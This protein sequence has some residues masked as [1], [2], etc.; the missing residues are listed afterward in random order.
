MT[1]GYVW[2]DA[3]QVVIDMLDDLGYACGELPK[4]AEALSDAFPVIWIVRAGGATDGITDRPIIE[5]DCIAPSRAQ[6]SATA[7]AVR[8]RIA[9]SAGTTHGG[10]LVDYAREITGRTPRPDIDPKLSAIQATFQLS[11]RPLL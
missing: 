6:A 1:A 4:T 2:P 3:E 5:V 9:G 10:V 8:A 11:F 7:Q